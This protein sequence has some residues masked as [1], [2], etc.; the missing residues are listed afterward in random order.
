VDISGGT[1]ES[2]AIIGGRTDGRAFSVVR[3]AKQPTECTH[4]EEEKQKKQ[5]GTTCE[6]RGAATYRSNAEVA[7]LLLDPDV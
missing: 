6:A 4:Q 7:R 1:E 2:G 3:E 5:G